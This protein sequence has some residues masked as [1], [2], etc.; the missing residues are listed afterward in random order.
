MYPPFGGLFEIHLSRH[1]RGP[2]TLPPGMCRKSE[3]EIVPEPEPA[4]REAVEVAVGRLL[5][6]PGRLPVSAWWR[7]GL[8]EGLELDP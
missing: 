3:I 4:L 8:A 7:A 1:F 6:P 2:T 5:E